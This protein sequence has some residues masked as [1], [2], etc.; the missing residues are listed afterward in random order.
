V[1]YKDDDTRK[2]QFFW[3]FW[4]KRDSLSPVNAYQSYMQEVKKVNKAFSTQVNPGFETDRGRVYLQYGPPNERLAET[5]EPSGSPYEIWQYYDLPGR[6]SN[7]KFVFKNQNVATNEFRLIH[8]D[9]R[10][11]VN[12]PRW[13]YEIYNSFKERSNSRNIDNTG[14]RDHYG[15]DLDNYFEG[16]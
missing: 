11:E 8:S 4:T 7:V 3:N 16:Q 6:E 5:H 14:V 10:G 12:N 2:Q 1:N 13:R 9:A 15:S